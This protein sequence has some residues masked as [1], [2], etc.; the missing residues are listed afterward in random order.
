MTLHD[1]SNL[2]VQD[3]EMG[4]RPESIPRGARASI[5]EPMS[6][7]N[8]LLAKTRVERSPSEVDEVSGRRH[9]GVLSQ[10]NP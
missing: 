10:G 7:R 5:G 4:Y 9:R 2:T 6:A 8:Q 1:I 3:R